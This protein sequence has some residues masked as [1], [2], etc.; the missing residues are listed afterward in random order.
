MKIQDSSHAAF[1]CT[2]YFTQCLILSILL[3][4][5][6]CVFI[7]FLLWWRSMAERI[8][9]Y[10]NTLKYNKIPKMR[11]IIEKNNHHLL[12]ALSGIRLCFHISHSC[13]LSNPLLRASINGLRGK[14]GISSCP[15]VCGARRILSTTQ[16]P[17]KSVIPI[18]KMGAYWEKLIYS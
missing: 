11:K 1:G 8:F 4:K 6:L 13:F 3:W 5:K 18:L 10:P 14:L 9:S 16:K 15:P 2:G 12:Q 7:W 17:G